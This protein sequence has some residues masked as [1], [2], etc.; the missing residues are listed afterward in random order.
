MY[1]IDK[2]FREEFQVL[3]Q[4]YLIDDFPEFVLY[5]ASSRDPAGIKLSLD[6]SLSDID[7]LILQ[8]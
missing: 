4:M 5:V 7:G 6:Y 1:F 8:N 3:T 2:S